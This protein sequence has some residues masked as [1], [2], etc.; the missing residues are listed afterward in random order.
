MSPYRNPGEVSTLAI[1]PYILLG[2]FVIF[3]NVPANLFAAG[4]LEICLYFVPLFFIGLTSEQDSTPIILAVFGLLNDIFSE[5]P[6]GFWAFL[7]VVFYL[8]CV[9]QR[10]L[11]SAANFGSYWVTFGV[12]VTMIYLVAY[13]L[14]FM[15]DDL[16][17]ATVPFLLSAAVCILFFPLVYFPFYLFGDAMGMSERN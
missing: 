3:N 10:S 6:L 7:F 12:L 5:M 8:L 17:I 16:Q 15:V 14:S 2:L 1:I 13:L 4:R 11:L 9:S